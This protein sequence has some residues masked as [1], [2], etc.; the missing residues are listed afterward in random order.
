MK[1]AYVQFQPFLCNLPQTLAALDPLIRSAASADLVVLPELCNSGYNFSDYQLAYNS[2]EEIGKSVFIDFL[3]SR[4]KEHGLYMVSGFNERENE[5][6]YN[7]AVLVGPEG[8]I[9]K[10][11]KL[12]LFMNEK[13][14]FEP[15]NAGLPIFDL[16]SIKIGMLV[17]FDWIYPEAWRILSLRGVDLVCHPSNLVLPGFAQKAIPIHSLINRIYIITANRIGQEGNLTF[18]GLST[19]SN[20]QGE[21]ILQASQG[22]PEVGLISIDIEMSR[23]KY[24]TSRNHLFHDRRPKEYSLLTAE[25]IASDTER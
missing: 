2:S 25:D 23:N 13:D 17:C 12:H 15:G 19:I 3:C 6:L 8:Y 11:R 14:Y 18:T 5:R 16:R 7:S 22:D 4:A 24:I 21:V 20:P 1:V 10:Y 9:G